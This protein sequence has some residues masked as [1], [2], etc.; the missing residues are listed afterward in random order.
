LDLLNDGGGFGEEAG[1][2]VT[3]VVWIGGREL[4][5]EMDVHLWVVR[6]VSE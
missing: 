3:V 4:C 5:D 2:N 6:F 1:G